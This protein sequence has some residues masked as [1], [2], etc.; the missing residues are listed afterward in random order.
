V[1][2]ESPAAGRVVGTSP[3]RDRVLLALALC[4]GLGLRVA[5][6]L[7]TAHTAL[8]WEAD[9]FLRCWEALPFVPL[10]RMRPPLPGWV[11]H[12]L[13]DAAQ[14]YTILAVRLLSVGLSLFGLLGAVVLGH[15]L[16]TRL[17]HRAPNRRAARAWIVAAWAVQ[18]TL[19]VGAA[20][21]LGDALLGG[22]LC[23]ALAAAV[24]LGSGGGT[25]LA[26]AAAPLRAAWL[27]LA[28]LGVVLAGG[29]GAACAVLVALI[30]FLAPVPPLRVALPPLLAVLLALSGGWWLQRGPDPERA[31]MPDTAPAWSLAALTEAPLAIDETE[32]LDPDLRALTVWEAAVHRARDMGALAVLRACSLRLVGDLLNPARFEHALALPGP[33]GLPGMLDLLLRGGVLLFAMA[34]ASMARPRIE[35]ALPRGGPVAGFVTL[36]VV[37][38]LSASGPFAF[39]PLD[40]VLIG[41]AGAGIACADRRHR[42]LR[43]LAFGIGGLLL[44]GLGLGAL[45]REQALSPWIT[46]LNATADQGPQLVRTLANGGPQEE[47]GEI[48]AANLLMDRMA[49][50]QRTPEA[51]LRHALRATQLAPLSPRATSAL[52]NAWLEN[53]DFTAAAALAASMRNETGGLTPDG[54]VLLGWVEHCEREW[55]TAA[56]Q[57]SSR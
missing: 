51:C 22:W 11:L 37:L 3:T 32:P 45:L 7:R 18:P 16:A 34:A 28:V 9:G 33:R 41:V 8:P 52:V 46:T 53:L 10:S 17:G 35:S 30:V 49:P 12:H 25:G 42:G 26:R 6:A 29:I 39:A 20:S 40:F 47:H 44:A 31:W 56:L 54:R 21:P 15:V 13:A 19:V 14:A 36:F 2:A 4:L 55:R 23:L 27:A 50:F 1:P 5:V 43:W 57:R 38:L 24:Q 48:F